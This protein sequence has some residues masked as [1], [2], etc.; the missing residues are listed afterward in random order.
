MD[1][2]L[3]IALLPVPSPRKEVAAGRARGLAN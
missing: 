2:V 1:D 3:K